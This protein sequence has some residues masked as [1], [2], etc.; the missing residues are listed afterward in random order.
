MYDTQSKN[1]CKSK[2][3]FFWVLL[4][5][6]RSLWYCFLW[7]MI[8]SYHYMRYAIIYYLLIWILFFSSTYAVTS[9]D[10]PIIQEKTQSPLLIG[11]N[12]EQQ[13]L[14]DYAWT[15]SQDFDFILTVFAESGFR[16]YAIGDQGR[17]F[18]V[19]QRRPDLWR[20][21]LTN[22]PRFADWHFQIDSCWNSY[23]IWRA[24]GKLKNRL[25]WYNVGLKHKDRFVMQ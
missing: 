12:T 20:W 5:L 15:I 1:I 11:G 7:S 21:R 22:D 18:G 4:F 14:I 6:Y 8:Y 19:C 23:T 24:N 16:P 3:Y 2:L 25:Y 17:A 13:E 10:I 9:N